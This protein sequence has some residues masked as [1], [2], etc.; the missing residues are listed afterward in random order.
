MSKIPHI[1]M[2]DHATDESCPHYDLGVSLRKQ[3]N[4]I[5]KLVAKLCDALKDEDDEE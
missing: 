3:F 1:G 2:C 5:R 4:T